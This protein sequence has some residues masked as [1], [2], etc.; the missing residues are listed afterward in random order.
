VNATPPDLCADRARPS[1]PVLDAIA[2]STRAKEAYDAA[3]QKKL[4][5]LVALANALYEAREAERA[6]ECALRE[7]IEQHGCT[8]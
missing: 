7:H 5:H 8:V 2:E 4:G 3:R 1:Q 6:A